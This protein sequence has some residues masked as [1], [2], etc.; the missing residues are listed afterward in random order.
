M[1]FRFVHT[2]PEDHTGYFAHYDHHRV[3]NGDLWHYLDIR[4][5]IREHQKAWLDEVDFWH[6]KLSECTLDREPLWW[7][8]PAS[9]LISWHPPVLKPIFFAIGLL[10]LGK[11]SDCK[12][13]YLLG[14]PAEVAEYLDEMDANAVIHRVGF[15][16][17]R[18]GRAISTGRTWF[19]R[20]MVVAWLRTI[21][22]IF[23][24][25]GRVMAA[26]SA[27][28]EKRGFHAKVIV[29][30]MLLNLDTLKKEGDH[31]YGY[32]FD[33]IPGLTR[34][35]IVWFYS[36][37]SRKKSD[38]IGLADY[39][40]EKG[41]QITTLE[42][43]CSNIDLVKV[44]FSSCRLLARFATLG[45]LLPALNVAGRR[46]QYI[47]EKF[48]FSK[49]HF[50]PPSLEIAFLL[51]AK[52][53]MALSNADTFVYPYEEKGIERAFLMASREMKKNIRTIGLA[54][55]VHNDGH[56]YLRVRKNGAVN[57]PRPDWIGVTG[58]TAAKWLEVQAGMDPRTMVVCG[59]K[60]H[61]N[62][63]PARWGLE[64]RHLRVLVLTGMGYEL[65]ILANYLEEARTLFQGCEVWIRRYPYDW[66]KEQDAG[67]SRL[68]HMDNSIQVNDD[69]LLNQLEWC[70]AAI[71]NST[72]AG[73]QSMLAGR[74]SI[75]AD[76]HDFVPLDPLLEKGDLSRTMRCFSGSEL[77]IALEKIRSMSHT[78]YV[79]A[80]KDQIAFAEK[81]YGPVDNDALFR[82]L[83]NPAMTI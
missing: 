23:V 81:I 15:K 25:A 46:S 37:K 30:S 16:P 61:V 75:Y 10:E 66:L 53:L 7:L 70:D 22:N 20:Q 57:A 3:P 56:L 2:L 31:F 42:E 45:P 40:E 63:F 33:A 58:P 48:F 71:F 14:C 8:M 43:L 59:S 68:Q 60:R 50:Q 49:I 18:F 32:M 76:L 47:S 72:S 41:Y 54:H 51:A 13:I 35:D 55:A 78:D 52:R 24:L 34:K 1:I 21:K 38:Y 67:I 77:Q 4:G 69:P 82:V 62:S 80:A 83:L 65:G 19:Y 64:K 73:L 29:F 36:A 79:A 28:M 17:C 6:S 12:E 44:F 9:R 11:Q 74:L 27:G 5:Y 26:R 39:G